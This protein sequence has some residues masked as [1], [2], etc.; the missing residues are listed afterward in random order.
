MRAK[1]SGETLKEIVT[2]VKKVSDIIAGIAAASAEQ[3]SGIEQVNKAIMQM[4]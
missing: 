2:S 4:D 1:Q 3:S